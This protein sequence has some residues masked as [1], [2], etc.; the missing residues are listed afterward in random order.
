MFCYIFPFYIVQK[1]LYFITIALQNLL[2]IQNY[3]ISSCHLFS[4]LSN[5]FKYFTRKI[6]CFRLIYIYIAHLNI[7]WFWILIALLE[8]NWIINILPVS[9]FFFLLF[10][11]GPN[12]FVVVFHQIY[13]SRTIFLHHFMFCLFVLFIYLCHDNWTRYYLCHTEKWDI[14]I[15]PYHK[16]SNKRMLSS[17]SSIH[18]LTLYIFIFITLLIL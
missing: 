15:F 2:T 8:I 14:Y 16:N 7:L 3:G 6:F 12:L 11:Y 9:I 10:N 4:L 1:L 17:P 5:T 13:H 18:I